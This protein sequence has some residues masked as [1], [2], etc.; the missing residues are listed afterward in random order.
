M[1]R[2]D[3]DKHPNPMTEKPV[4]PSPTSPTPVMATGASKED[5][6]KDRVEH[7]NKAELRAAAT[8]EDKELN[9]AAR[10]ELAVRGIRPE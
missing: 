8:G 6:I 5:Q 10:K 1:A 3:S 9:E 4:P 7:M 2:D